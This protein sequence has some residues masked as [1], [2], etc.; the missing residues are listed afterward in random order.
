MGRRSEMRT[1]EEEKKK[2]EFIQ[3][4]RQT[5]PSSTG[6]KLKLLYAVLLQSQERTFKQEI[7]LVVCK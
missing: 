4:Q 1:E 3:L 7:Y 5:T 2:K 6:I